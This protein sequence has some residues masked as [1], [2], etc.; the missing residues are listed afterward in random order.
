M[1]LGQ[2]YNRVSNVVQTMVI[3]MLDYKRGKHFVY[4][5][6]QTFEWKIT[7]MFFF[8]K[9]DDKCRCGNGYG[10]FGLASSNGLS[11]NVPCSLLTNQ[12]CGGL[13]A[14]SIYSTSCSGS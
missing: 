11:C 14:N 2:Q 1:A 13:N 3:H 7:F 10:S 6:F 9:S 4:Y 12:M 8:S 5:T